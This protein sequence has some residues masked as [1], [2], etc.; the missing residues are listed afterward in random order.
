MLAD[1]VKALKGE[2]HA[3]TDGHPT[4]DLPLEAVIPGDFVPNEN[5]RISL[6]RRLAAVDDKDQLL[7]LVREIKDRFGPLPQ[8]VKNLVRLVQLKLLCMEAG[9][10][11]ISITEARVVVALNDE[12]QLSQREQ[13]VF[14][15]LYTPTVRQ[16]RAGVRPAL[17]RIMISSHQVS[18]GYNRNE[19]NE[20][21]KRLTELL[22]KLRERE[23]T[24]PPAGT[25]GRPVAK[26]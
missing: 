7:A 12:A 25:R 23:Q 9:V 6:Y 4:I 24:R 26:T 13:R 15:G 22:E 21:L 20:L 14:T 10:A 19:R 1:A 16:A 8:P 2:K 5:Q 11:D 17:P 18:F 3:G